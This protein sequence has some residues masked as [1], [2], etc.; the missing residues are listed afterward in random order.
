[1]ALLMAA[2]LLLSG[3]ADDP[4]AEQQSG[5][6]PNR[7]AEASQTARYQPMIGGNRSSAYRL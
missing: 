7:D 4:P 1:M 6:R 3:P 2:M 5:S